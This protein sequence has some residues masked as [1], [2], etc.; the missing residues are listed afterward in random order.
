MLWS[1]SPTH[2]CLLFTF[3]PQV[4]AAAAQAEAAL[5]AFQQGAASTGLATIAPVADL[6]AGSAGANM[7]AAG[8]A[9]A[10]AAA[11]TGAYPGPPPVTMAVT[12][13]LAQLG[14]VLVNEIGSS[15][16]PTPF[17]CVSGMITADVLEDDEEYAEVSPNQLVCPS[18]SPLS[19]VNL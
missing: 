3:I 13:P 12:D 10:A 19:V 1:H 6:A 5:A 7:A 17:L 18:H 8:N 14:G 16:V 4:N 9:A 2:C 11:G 15:R